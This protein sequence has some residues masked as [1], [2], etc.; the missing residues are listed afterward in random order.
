MNL[1]EFLILGFAAFRIT[2][3]FV[4]DAILDEPRQWIYKKLEV[5]K[6]RGGGIKVDDDDIV[7]K[8]LGIL[9]TCPWC[10]GFWV[11][12]L[13]YIFYT[14]DFSIINIFAVAGIQSFLNIASL[15]LEKDH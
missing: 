15:W 13:L 3:L 4:F 11:S 6:K 14:A 8:K 10:V 1:V 5:R 2:R 7:K 12:A 9:S